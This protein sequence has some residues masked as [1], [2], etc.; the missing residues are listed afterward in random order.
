MRPVDLLIFNAREPHAVS[1]RAK[2][3]DEIFCVSI[4]L[5]TAV[6]VIGLNDNSI[7]RSPMEDLIFNYQL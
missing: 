2:S 5:K 4:Y 1:S 7:K 3:S 6:V